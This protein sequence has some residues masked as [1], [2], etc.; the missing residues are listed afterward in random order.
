MSFRRLDCA[1]C[2][3]VAISAGISVSG[4]GLIH[5]VERAPAPP[6]TLPEAYSVKA[7][8]QDSHA[9]WWASFESPPLQEVITQALDGNLGLVQ[10]FSRLDQAKAML[11]GARAGHRDIR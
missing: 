5:K 11:Q 4:C 3:A 9:Q 6:V 7:Q 10:A 2:T 1:F 8:G